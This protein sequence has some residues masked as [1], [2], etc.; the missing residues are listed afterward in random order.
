MGH[1]WNAEAHPTMNTR[2]PKDYWLAPGYL[3]CSEVL[4]KKKNTMCNGWEYFAGPERHQLE[5]LL[6]DA[7][8]T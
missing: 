2:S 7:L 8:S 1:A 5:H 3:W 4:E 6:C